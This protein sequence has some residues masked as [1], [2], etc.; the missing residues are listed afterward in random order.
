MSQGHKRVSVSKVTHRVSVKMKR[1][2]NPTKSLKS[3]YHFMLIDRYNKLI[4]IKVDRY[5]K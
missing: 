5:K 2:G 1:Q 3:R 4:S